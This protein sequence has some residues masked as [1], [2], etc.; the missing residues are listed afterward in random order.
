MRL[1]I[2]A[3]SFLK[4]S[5]MK[6][7]F[8]LFIISVLGISILSS[9]SKEEK[10]Q[11]SAHDNF[12][13]SLSSADTTEVLDLCQQFFAKLAAGDKESAIGM[14]SM[15]DEQGAILP[16]SEEKRNSL[17]KQFTLFPVL[18]NHLVDYK[19]GDA[20]DNLMR[21]KVVFAKDEQGKEESINFGLNPIRMDGK[22]Y[23]TVRNASAKVA[24]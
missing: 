24:Q 15:S 18:D 5:F 1:S 21:F 17:N 3:H 20:A 8:Y 6:K 10:P 13:A 7:V 2:E 9:C 23:L 14:L 22:W 4:Y 12:V 19:F 16:L 11:P